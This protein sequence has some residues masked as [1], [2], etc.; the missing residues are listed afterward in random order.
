MAGLSRPTVSAFENSKV[1][2]YEKTRAAI[3]AALESQGVVFTN[4]DQPGFYMTKRKKLQA[5]ADEP[6]A[7]GPVESGDDMPDAGAE[8]IA[9]H[10]DPRGAI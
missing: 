5:Q 7:Q 1:R 6:T 9:G 3:Q 2:T 10:E 8:P 4:G